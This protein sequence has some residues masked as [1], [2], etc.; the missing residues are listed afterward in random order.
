[1]A[2]R[3]QPSRGDE[4]LALLHRLTASDPTTWP[5][6]ERILFEAA[7]LMA[8]RGYHGATTREIAEAVGIQQPSIF[9]H[10]AS[11]AA[12]VTELFEYDQVIPSERIDA[13]V[14]EGGSPAVQLYRY[15]EWQTRW[16]TELPFDLRGLGAELIDELELP[17][18]RRAL[19]NFRRTLNRIVRS[20]VEMGQFY[21]DGHDFLYPALNALAWEAVRS[22]RAEPQRRSVRHLADSAASFVLRA[23]LADRTS[24][25]DVRS[26]AASLGA[27]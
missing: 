9:N 12:I 5:T 7:A 2:T 24:I 14:R 8:T 26:E 4:R 11:K 18:P 22:R 15:V 20:G 27:D 10:F 6:R 23:T 17:R 25:D 21:S 3:E 16:Y 19:Q 13:I 1:M